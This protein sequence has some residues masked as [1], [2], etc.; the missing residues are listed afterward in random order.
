MPALERGKSGVETPLVIPILVA[1]G[2]ELDRTGHG[3]IL[4]E[5]LKKLDNLAAW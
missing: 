4:S 5:Q 3:K 2:H 1:G